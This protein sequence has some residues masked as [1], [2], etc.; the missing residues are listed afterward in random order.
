MLVERERLKRERR[1]SWRRGGARVSMA[2][3]IESAP[4]AEEEFAERSAEKYSALVKGS[5]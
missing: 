1:S 5:V 2:K 3:L 4:G